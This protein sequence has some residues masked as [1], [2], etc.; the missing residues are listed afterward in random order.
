MRLELE[1]QKR[2]CPTS[3]SPGGPGMGVGEAADPSRLPAGISAKA[4][5]AGSTGEAV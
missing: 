2:L 4:T 3:A 5:G 1:M